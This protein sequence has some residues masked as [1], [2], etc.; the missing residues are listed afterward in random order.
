MG[1]VGSQVSSKWQILMARVQSVDSHTVGVSK[2]KDRETFTQV[3]LCQL[4]RQNL[5]GWGPGE[6][7]DTHIEGVWNR[8]EKVTSAYPR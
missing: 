4:K 7:I 2:Y 8:K 6:S 3:V 1:S 5:D